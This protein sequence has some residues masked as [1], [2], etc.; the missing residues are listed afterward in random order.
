MTEHLDVD[1][2]VDPACPWAWLTSRWL[3]EV[4]RVRPVR[5]R[6][7]LFDLAEVNR[8]TDEGSARDSHAAGERALRVL[9]AARHE[10]GADL[11]DRLYTELGEARQ[12]LG[13][14]L[15]SLETLERCT[16]AAGLTP[17]FAE[18]SL[19]DPGTLEEVLAEHAEAAAAGVFGVPTLRLE[20]SAPWFGP[21]IDRRITG[22]EAGA[23]WDAVVPILS[24]PFLF[25]MKRTRTD[26]ARVGRYR[27]A[28]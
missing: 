12:E 9:V 10:G 15:G 24:N 25:E 18:Q 8:A 20:G 5:V 13:D 21:V 19:S 6:T 27:V 17:G 1:L 3:R 4:E 14:D 23:L 22:Q 7:R 2:W 11:V 26:K 28:A 16:T